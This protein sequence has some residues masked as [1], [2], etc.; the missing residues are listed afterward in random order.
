MKNWWYYYRWYV[1]S[2]LVL[3]GICF[4]LI[5][6]FFGWFKKSPDLQIAYV[7]QLS[8]IHI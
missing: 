3:F 1:I 8:L 7:G 2:G 4:Y 5:G 6:N